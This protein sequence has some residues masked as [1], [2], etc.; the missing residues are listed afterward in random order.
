MKIQFKFGPLYM[1]SIWWTTQSVYSEKD[2]YLPEAVFDDMETELR[3][4]E[5]HK[6]YMYSKY[7][8]QDDYTG[9]YE[10][11]TWDLSKAFRLRLLN[12]YKK[13]T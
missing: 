5:L 12:T 4:L 7:F 6:L 9:D 2:S 10:Y 11:N 3:S 1:F 13:L 8:D